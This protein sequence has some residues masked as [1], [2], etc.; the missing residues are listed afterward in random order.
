MVSAVFYIPDHDTASEERSVHERT[1]RENFPGSN[2]ENSA[3]VLGCGI[4]GRQDIT[5][6]AIAFV[7]ATV[8]MLARSGEIFGD[9]S[10]MRGITS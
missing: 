9:T 2:Q 7:L 8:A 4:Q 6:L 10:A 5:V 3:F 1:N